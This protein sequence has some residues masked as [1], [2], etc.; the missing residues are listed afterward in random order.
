MIRAG[1][2]HAAW[3]EGR[4]A[5]LDLVLERWPDARTL[6]SIEKEHANVWAPRLWAAF[7]DLDMHASDW[8]LCLNDDVT[9]APRDVVR[10]MF[11]ALPENVN[12]VSLATI[13]SEAKKALSVGDRFIASYC[14]TG[15]GYAIRRS[16]IPQLLEFHAKTLTPGMRAKMNEDEV[17][18]HFAWSMQSPFWHCL[19]ALVRHDVNVSSTLGYDNHPGRVANVLWDE[20]PDIDLDSW[21]IPSSV[22]CCAHPWIGEG[23]MR[24]VRR[25]YQNGWDFD[26]V[27]VFCAV[28]PILI[29]SPTT[30]AGICGRCV[31]EAVG[32]VLTNARVG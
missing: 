12:L 11:E 1:I 31:S 21:P 4:R 24:A 6:V 25:A 13:Q 7:L 19:P 14:A 18:S 28:A 26:D 8:C 16:L 15:P 32:H 27:C 2:A 30:G 22:A 3:A 20:N 9:T 17:L 10:A 23:R 29:M 5:S